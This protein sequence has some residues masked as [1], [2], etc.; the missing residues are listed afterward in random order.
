MAVEQVGRRWWTVPSTEQG[1][2]L[3]FH[4]GPWTEDDYL[5]LPE[6]RARVELLDGALLVNP[7]PGVMHQR[8][9]ARLWLAL[10]AL[11]PSGM[12]VLEAVNVRVAPGRLLIPDLAVLRSR[13]DDATVVDAADVLMVT[14][15]VSA[16]SVAADRAIKPRLYAAAGIRAYVRIELSGGPLRAFTCH[17]TDGVYAE[18]PDSSGNPVLRLTSP[19]D[20]EVDLA[21]LLSAERAGR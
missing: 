20:A 19:F 7:A 3:R 5:A 15:I 16:G 18:T 17:L 1:L 13:L 11:R 2:D 14:E 9:S 10:E 21:A 4:P 12:E 6:D 8:L